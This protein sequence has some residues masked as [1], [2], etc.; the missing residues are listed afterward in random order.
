MRRYKPKQDIA[1]A[2]TSENSV[3]APQNHFGEQII[4]V[5]NQIYDF[6]FPRNLKHNVYRNNPATLKGLWIKIQK[7]I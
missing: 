2:H 1:P 7:V 3:L 5:S 4:P 6:Y